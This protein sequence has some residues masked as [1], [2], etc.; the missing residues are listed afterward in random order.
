MR[1]AV[2][3]DYDMKFRYFDSTAFV[4]N[5]LYIE[6][7]SGWNCDLRVR[8]A[9]I[10][11]KYGSGTYTLTRNKY[12]YASVP[13]DMPTKIYISRMVELL[14][15]EPES[16]RA[17]DVK[18]EISLQLS[19]YEYDVI[20][21]F[22]FSA[23]WGSIA[24][25]DRF[26]ALGAYAVD[27]DHL[28]FNRNVVFFKNFPF[29]LSLYQFAQSVIPTVRFDNA[30]TVT[31]SWPTRLK[32]TRIEKYETVGPS[33]AIANHVEELVYFERNNIIL[34]KCSGEWYLNWVTNNGY[35]S[36]DTFAIGGT[37]NNKPKANQEYVIAED[38]IDF[39][40]KYNGSTLQKDN[41]Y[42][43]VG[44]RHINIKKDYGRAAARCLEVRYKVSAKDST[45][46]VFDKTFDFTFRNSGDSTAI[47]NIIISNQTAGY[48]LRWIDPQGNLQYFLFTKG[49]T[50]EKITIDKTGK[51]DLHDI[52]GMSF[53][54]IV[55]KNTTDIAKTCK[56]GATGL[57]D[58][59]YSY[60]KTIGSA[61]FVDMFLGYDSNN[62]ELWVPV[63]VEASTYDFEERDVLHN[64]ELKISFPAYT[65]QTL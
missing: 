54:N 8:V 62:N 27:G 20:H 10:Q 36:S 23:I 60:V 2:V 41:I 22:S 33:S 32:L 5:P 38:G 53:A 48:Y 43:D 6:V 56:C 59:I 44:F 19:Q 30:T 57:S 37:N 24:P 47:V 55:R 50:S 40:F 7:L 42:G 16:V 25:G 3:E 39:I 45:W 21:S 46:S 52:G 64:I 4:F 65:P 14:F 12:I 11:K 28:A 18:V 13:A 51:E 31:H 34:C 29:N 17:L 26:N 63:T 49:K 9:V 35:A 15:E 58:S 1:Y 61:Y